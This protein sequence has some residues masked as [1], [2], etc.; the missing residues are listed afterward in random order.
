MEKKISTRVELTDEETLHFG[1]K[2]EVY[3]LNENVSIRNK[4]TG[5][6][7]QELNPGILW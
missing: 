3:V 4:P 7:E 6:E 1:E 5:P 2:R